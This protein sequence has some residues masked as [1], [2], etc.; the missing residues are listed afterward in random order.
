MSVGRVSPPYMW[1][2]SARTDYLRLTIS[3]LHFTISY[4]IGA[5]ASTRVS[6]ELGAGNPEAVRVAIYASMF[7]AITEE[8]IM[9]QN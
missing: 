2:F 3:T 8:S 1:I 4:A 7:L 5:A 9:T 6:N